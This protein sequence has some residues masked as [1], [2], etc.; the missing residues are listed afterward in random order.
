MIFL[1]NKSTIEG[2][3]KEGK[4]KERN[5][6][7]D[8]KKGIS[9]DKLINHILWYGIWRKDKNVSIKFQKNS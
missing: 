8:W 1:K 4:K 5:L 9:K 6:K 7:K 3:E 2:R